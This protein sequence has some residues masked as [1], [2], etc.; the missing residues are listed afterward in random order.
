MKL[1]SIRK[2]AINYR[3]KGYSYNMISKKLGVAK[4][5]LSYWLK[6][7]SYSPN[8]K[9]MNRISNACIKS[10]YTR[11]KRKIENIQKAKKIAKKEVGKLTKR[12]LFMLGIGLYWGEGDKRSKESV[13]M[14][15]SD[16]EII[17][18]AIKWLKEICGLNT[19]NFTLTIHTYPDNKI[20]EDINYWSKVT[21]I[22][23]DQFKKT[24][25]DK[26]KNKSSK[27]KRLLPH[28]TV[29]LVVKSNGKKEFGVFLF[30]RIMGWIETTTNQI[31][32]RV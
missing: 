19:K 23:K 29:K 26:R 14:I 17:K 13:R 24:Q 25:I 12:D 3:K 9:V 31:N 28:G 1:L 32:K 6:N 10:I 16:P 8:K 21:E 18:T 5:T 27:K 22:P 11:R 7:V 30:R 2:E 20:A 4:S 15:N